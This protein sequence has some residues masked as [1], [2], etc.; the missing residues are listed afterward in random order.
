MYK[1]Q[2]DEEDG[3]AEMMMVVGKQQAFQTPTA[4][5]DAIN[6]SRGPRKSV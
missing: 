1:G 5:G 3:L 6:S 4:V 2:R